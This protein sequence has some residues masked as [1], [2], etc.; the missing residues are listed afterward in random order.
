MGGFDDG[1]WQWFVIFVGDLQGQV[2]VFCVYQGGEFVQDCDV[3]MRVELVVVVFEYLFGGVEFV[4]QCGG[5]VNVDFCDGC[6]VESLYDGQYVEF[7]VKGRVCLCVVDYWCV[8]VQ[9]IYQ[10]VGVF[11]IVDWYIYYV[12]VVIDEGGFDYWYQLVDGCYLGVFGVVGFGVFYEIWIVKLYVEVFEIIYC[13][14]LVDYVVSVV[15][16]DCYYQVE[17]QLYGGFYFL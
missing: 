17:F 11:G 5:I 12:N 13:L 14:F 8:I 10:Y 15:I 7:F 1:I 16:E 9:F 2:F 4:F 6:V 3:L